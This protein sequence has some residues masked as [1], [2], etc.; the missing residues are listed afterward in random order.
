[1]L[2]KN[3]ELLGHKLGFLQEKR[4]HFKSAGSHKSPRFCLSRHLAIHGQCHSPSLFCPSPVKCAL[5]LFSLTAVSFGIKAVRENCC[6][7]LWGTF[8]H[9]L[10][11]LFLGGFWHVCFISHQP[12]FPPCSLAMRLCLWPFYLPL[13]TKIKMYSVHLCSHGSKGISLKIPNKEAPTLTATESCLPDSWC[14]CKK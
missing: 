2:R 3:K 5:T 11:A 9:V 1:M 7:A 14:L 4:N 8:S 13:P 10:L 12:A 6:F